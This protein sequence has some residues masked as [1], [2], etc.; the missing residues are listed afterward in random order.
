M[1]LA[2]NMMG[3][4]FSS[5]QLRALN[6]TVDD[7]VTAAGTAITDAFDLTA[8]ISIVDS[9]ASGAGVQLYDG[10]IG[11]EQ[12]VFNNTTTQCLVYPPVATSGINQVAV[13]SAVV[14]PSKTCGRYQKVSV[15]QIVAFHSA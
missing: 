6:G 3:G 13:G 9:C 8:D 2:K 5:G 11:D 4:G 12:V 15:T 1:G 7:S 14:L 10:N